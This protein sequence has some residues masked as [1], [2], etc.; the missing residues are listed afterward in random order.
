MLLQHVFGG[1]CSPHING[2]LFSQ[3]SNISNHFVK[4]LK[5]SALHI[6]SLSYFCHAQ[7]RGA[8]RRLPFGL[9]CCV[10]CLILTTVSEELIASIM[11]V[12]NPASSF[13]MSVS[14]YLTTLCYIPE[15]AI[16]SYSLH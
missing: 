9:L 7:H 1:W 6:I 15:T 11:R 2:F 13:E 14:I 8:G 10:F 3:C 12:M 4:H 5:H 16:Y